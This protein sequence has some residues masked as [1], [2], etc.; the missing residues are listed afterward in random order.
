MFGKF[1]G[2]L[3]KNV[4][5]K[6]SMWVVNGL[7]WLF[8]ALI[9]F[10]IPA[11][12]H[13]S[14]LYLWTNSMFNFNLM[15]VIF[16]AIYCS[17]LA[18]CIFNQPREDGSELVI[19]SKPIARWKIINV[20]FLVYLTF[21]FLNTVID[22]ILPLFCLCLGKYD[23]IT[24][25]NG[26]D[27]SKLGS[28][29][30]S[31]FI[32][33]LVIC[34]F[35]GSIAILISMR[36]N[37]PVIMVSTIAIAIVFE[38]I[39]MVMPMVV[40]S[41][42]EVAT[43]RYAI[44]INTSN[45]YDRDKKRAR[46]FMTSN[47]GILS[48]DGLIEHTI[49]EWN[50]IVQKASGLGIINDIDIGGQMASMYQLLKLDGLDDADLSM[51]GANSTFK[52]NVDKSSNVFDYYDPKIAVDDNNGFFPIIYPNKTDDFW[53]YTI[54]GIDQLRY[55]IYEAIGC[56]PS[57]VFIIDDISSKLSSKFI[58][59]TEFSFTN[60]DGKNVIQESKDSSGEYQANGALEY[61]QLR[62]KFFNYVLGNAS[63]PY[64]TS[65][66][67]N[68]AF[69]LDIYKFLCMPLHKFNDSTKVLSDTGIESVIGKKLS[70]IDNK[71]FSTALAKVSLN[72]SFDLWDLFYGRH[73]NK[74]KMSLSDYSSNL[75]INKLI[76]EWPTTTWQLYNSTEVDN[77]EFF[78]NY[79][80][81]FYSSFLDAGKADINKQ[82]G[83]ATAYGRFY[84][85]INLKAFTLKNIDG[86][87]IPNPSSIKVERDDSFDLNTMRNAISSIRELRSAYWYSVNR[88]VPNEQAIVIWLVFS[89]I[90]FAIT[91]VI[92]RRTDIK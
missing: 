36:G 81:L 2:Y 63:I 87:K 76:S 19:F 28:L 16:L 32:A 89:L 52:F 13:V 86:F 1:Y 43:D 84:K 11:P 29:E 3:V 35:F 51:Y 10:I 5:N 18:V 15:T 17:I 79:R 27:V 48:D 77:Q 56:K 4:I 59:A 45:Y 58:D 49:Y 53:G 9:F 33:T 61:A 40:K 67:G 23:A 20:K 73:L 42:S 83:P 6:K 69:F 38:L 46:C 31:I 85:I 47:D 7:V 26:F 50:N 71:E 92:Y 82:G 24:N 39:S 44:E 21:V 54:Y 55:S 57:S 25:P 70:E 88:Y 65:D 22:M 34:L 66:E 41:P 60:K 90:L 30:L 8:F 37:K 68:N 78:N 91:F 80:F 14:P 75:F 62:N 12:L 72:L 74:Y 64:D